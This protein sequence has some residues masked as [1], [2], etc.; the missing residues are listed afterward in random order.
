MFP[1]IPA[2]IYVF[3]SHLYSCFL[4]S[5]LDGPSWSWSSDNQARKL[6]ADPG[7]RCTVG[8]T[9][10][11]MLGDRSKYCMA[12][13][14]PC[15]RTMARRAFRAGPTYGCAW[16]DSG[17]RRRRKN[18]NSSLALKDWHPSEPTSPKRLS[19]QALCSRSWRSRAASA[20]MT[21]AALTQVA[22]VWRLRQLRRRS[23]SAVKSCSSE[24]SSSG[25]HWTSSSNGSTLLM[26]RRPTEVCSPST[27]WIHTHR[28]NSSHQPLTI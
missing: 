10:P 14:K 27:A 2:Y 26:P 7:Q 18:S 28:Q 19:A 21:M 16:L 3:S 8:T 11:A 9:M 13:S 4:L 25:S 12:L 15:L 23:Q 17:S 24:E 6:K 5:L 1:V 22:R 20:R